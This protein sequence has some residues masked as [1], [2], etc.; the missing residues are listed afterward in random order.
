M[1][2][3]KGGRFGAFVLEYL[4]G[5]KEFDGGNSSLVVFVDDRGRS[6]SASSCSILMLRV[7]ILCGNDFALVEILPEP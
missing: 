5:Y 3:L 6:S 1:A 4:L 2:F 7:M